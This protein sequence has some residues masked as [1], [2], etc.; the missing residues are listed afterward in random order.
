MVL[1]APSPFNTNI[2]IGTEPS[3]CVL[4]PTHVTHTT[5]IGYNMN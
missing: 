2:E 3:H 4:D 1:L 5:F